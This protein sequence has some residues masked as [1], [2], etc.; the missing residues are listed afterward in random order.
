ME[1]KLYYQDPY[2]KSFKTEIVNQQQDEQGNWYVL[3]QQTAFYPTGGG[4]PF[5]TGTLND[6]PVTAVGR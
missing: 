5:D 2:I 1:T 3:L 4:Q 6:I